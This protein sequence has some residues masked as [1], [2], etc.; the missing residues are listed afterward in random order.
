MEVPARVSIYRMMLEYSGYRPH[1]LHLDEQNGVR[2]CSDSASAAGSAFAVGLG[3]QLVENIDVLSAQSQSEVLRLDNGVWSLQEQLLKNT[4]LAFFGPALQ[5]PGLLYVHPWCWTEESVQRQ[6]DSTLASTHLRE[7]VLDPCG[8]V[9]VGFDEAGV[10]GLTLP[11][12]LHW[13]TPC[14]TSRLSKVCETHRIYHGGRLS[15]TTYRETIRVAHRARTADFVLVGG[16]AVPVEPALQTHALDRRRLIKII[17][18]RLFRFVRLESLS[19]RG[20]HSVVQDTLTFSFDADNGRLNS[21]DSCSHE[22]S[23]HYTAMSDF[24]RS[25]FGIWMNRHL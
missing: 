14:L 8:D 3:Q 9:F 18:N 22:F 7:C 15:S 19:A 25:H 21:V 4:A 6:F 2:R 1:L 13:H 10:S 23:P 16:A 11:R 24:E 20:F 5:Q 12:G 17:D